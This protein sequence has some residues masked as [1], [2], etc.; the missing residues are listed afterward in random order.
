[1]KVQRNAKRRQKKQL[2]KYNYAWIFFKT[3]NVPLNFL[4]KVA[5]PLRKY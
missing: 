3:T 4:G 2:K 5:I 1:M